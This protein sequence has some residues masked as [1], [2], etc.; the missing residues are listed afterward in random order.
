MGEEQ[1]LN[2]LML[3]RTEE[4]LLLLLLP[5]QPSPPLDEG[6]KW[7]WASRPT[8]PQWPLEYTAASLLQMEPKS[9]FIQGLTE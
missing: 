6:E 1:L 4:V 5:P 3:P 2:V 7:R 8:P 9:G